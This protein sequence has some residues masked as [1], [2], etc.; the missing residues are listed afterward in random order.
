MIVEEQSRLPSK[1]GVNPNPL[2]NSPTG[3]ARI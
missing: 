2:S 3:D 1:V